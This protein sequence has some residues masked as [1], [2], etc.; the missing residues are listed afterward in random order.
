MVHLTEVPI[1]AACFAKLP[2]RGA[3]TAHKQWLSSNF[4][5]GG[6]GGGI[7]VDTD[8]AAGAFMF[9]HKELMGAGE[10][11]VDSCRE[12]GRASWCSTP[13]LSARCSLTRG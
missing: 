2:G 1:S 13:C 12:I 7:R 10:A 8:K 3:D 11:V 5:V 9:G 4:G 6:K